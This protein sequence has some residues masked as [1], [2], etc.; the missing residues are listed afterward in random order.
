MLFYWLYLLG[1]YALLSCFGAAV[2]AGTIAI[3]LRR[4]SAFSAAIAIIVLPLIAQRSAPRAEVFTTLM[5][6][7]YLSLLWENYQTGQARLIWLP[8]LMVAWVNLHLGFIA[9]LALIGG[10]VGLEILEMLFGK[11][12]RVAALDRLRRAWPW[13]LATA[14]ATLINPWGWNLYSALVRQNRAMATHARFIA[15]WESA[16]WSWH[17]SLGTFSQQPNQY[18]LALLQSSS[19]SRDSWRWCRRSRERRSC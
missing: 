10:F 9:G 5:F 4:G 2:C 18:T 11:A 15:E 12:R 1:G 14:I 8:L 6:A 16:H 19:S 17:G 3:L 13:Y 7:A